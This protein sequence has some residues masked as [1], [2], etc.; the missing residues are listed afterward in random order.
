MVNLYIFRLRLNFLGG[1]HT[2]SLLHM[3]VKLFVYN[4]NLHLEYSVHLLGHS[5]CMHCQIFPCNWE[6]GYGLLDFQIL[7]A[8]FQIPFPSGSQAV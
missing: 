2:L 8:G 6:V 7:N 3:K 4:L 1:H 5:S